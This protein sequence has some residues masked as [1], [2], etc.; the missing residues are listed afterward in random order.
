MMRAV[1]VERVSSISVLVFSLER[2]LAGLYKLAE[3]RGQPKGQIADK[4]V[5]LFKT[6]HICK[7]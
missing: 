1:L 7:R 5:F 2:I 3:H 6:I 4:R